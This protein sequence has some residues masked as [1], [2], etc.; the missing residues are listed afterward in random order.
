[1]D[2]SQLVNL[3]P[4]IMALGIATQQSEQ[5]RNDEDKIQT[6]RMMDKD[7]KY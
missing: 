4:Y 5:R 2:E 7:N 3:G 1:M 6:G